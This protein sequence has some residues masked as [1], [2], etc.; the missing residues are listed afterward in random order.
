MGAGNPGGI[1]D[2]H[3]ILSV[4][5]KSMNLPPLIKQA[6]DV[7]AGY[8]D[9]ALT[10]LLIVGAIIIAI[11]AVKGAPLLKAAVLAWIVMP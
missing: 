11:I 10:I 3:C 8:P 1:R 9:N 2:L 5:G 4:E 7:F 6:N